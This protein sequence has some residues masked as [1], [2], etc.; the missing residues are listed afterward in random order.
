VRV[1]IAAVAAVVSG[2]APPAR[3]IAIT[4]DDLPIAWRA[5]A[6]HRL[7]PRAHRQAAAPIGEHHG[8]TIG[9]V[10]EGTLAGGAVDPDRV[11]LLRRWLDAGLELGT[12]TYSHADFH[13]TPRGDFE[14]DVI[15]G[16]ATTRRL[17]EE[18]GGTLRFFRHPFLHTGRNLAVR[19]E[20]E[21]FL[22]SRGY[23]IAPVTIETT[24]T[25]LRARTTAACSAAM[26]LS[27][28][29]RLPGRT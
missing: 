18:R 26:P 10:N 28:S 14:A 13:T 8:P 9:F 21:R 7:E 23:R 20:L 2:P 4:F 19:A 25:F 1:V 11:A 22:A 24:N 15:K 5:A 6:R 12:H 3:E 17:M 27:R 16:E 29:Q